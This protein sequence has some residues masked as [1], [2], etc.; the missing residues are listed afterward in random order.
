MAIVIE[1]LIVSGTG[2][3]FCGRKQGSRMVS[4]YSGSRV[5]DASEQPQNILKQEGDQPEVFVHIDTSN[6]GKK[7]CNDVLRSEDKELG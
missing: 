1:D 7:E 2:R 4:C 5:Q 6:I 3:R